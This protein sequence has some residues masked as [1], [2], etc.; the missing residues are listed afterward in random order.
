MHLRENMQIYANL[1]IM[2]IFRALVININE[3]VIYIIDITCLTEALLYP[4]KKQNATLMIDL[5][6]KIFNNNNRSNLLNWR[7]ITAFFNCY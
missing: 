1:G 3:V 4:E 5:N 2:H 7:V 6:R